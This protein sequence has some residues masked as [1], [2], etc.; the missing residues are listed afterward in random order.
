[1]M[2]T[3]CPLCNGEIQVSEGPFIGTQLMCL[4]CYS[5]FEV[6]WL[7][8][9]TLDLL[10]GRTA[11]DYDDNHE[12]QTKAGVA[13]FETKDLAEGISSVFEKRRGKFT[14]E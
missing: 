9:L 12:F 7:F 1:M 11:T 13:C 6:T 5:N 10:D 8:P 2:V 3:Q 4:H 14:G